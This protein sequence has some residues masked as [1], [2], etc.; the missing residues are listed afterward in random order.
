M[1]LGFFNYVYIYMY[2][3]IGRK[4]LYTTI[5][6]NRYIYTAVVLSLQKV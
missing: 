6:R 4:K 5:G 3:T 1:V 2:T